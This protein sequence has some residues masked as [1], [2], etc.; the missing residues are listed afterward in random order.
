MPV[1]VKTDRVYARDVNARIAF[2]QREGWKIVAVLP[3]DDGDVLIV[4][5]RQEGKGKQAVFA[6][7]S[8]GSKPKKNSSAVGCLFLLLIAVG[9]YGVFILPN[10][11]RSNSS[12]R[13]AF[14]SLTQVAQNSRNMRQTLRAQSSITPRQTQV[15][16]A[17]TQVNT[18]TVEPSQVIEATALP[19]NPRPSASTP[20]SFGGLSNNSSQSDADATPIE[21]LTPVPAVAALTS[22]ERIA[23]EFWINRPTPDVENFVTD[24]PTYEI[25][26]TST[27]RTIES[28]AVPLGSNSSN[29][30]AQTGLAPACNSGI[31]GLSSGGFNA[32]TQYYYDAG[33]Y[34]R[35]NYIPANMQPY[36]SFD[37]VNFMI[38]VSSSSQIPVPF[39][40]LP[41]QNTTQILGV[42]V[43]YITEINSFSD[44][45]VFFN[46][47]LN[48]RGISGGVSY[49]GSL[50]TQND[51]GALFE[52]FNRFLTTF[53][54]ACG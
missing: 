44:G 21:F 41:G 48:G 6:G 13:N 29:A 8:A 17:V 49:F 2:L 1:V 27:V 16:Q 7:T 38:E 35:I 34:R 30:Q 12:N 45:N 39:Y 54:R 37:D 25:R 14:A 50:V 23:T 26:P 28:T 31:I 46:F 22:A 9:C 4:H 33:S 5:E 10:A 47:T 32:D 24:T 36:R 40:G 53:I 42:S 43:T 20:L 19:D 3:Q 15:V 52:D 18:S 11:A 51:S